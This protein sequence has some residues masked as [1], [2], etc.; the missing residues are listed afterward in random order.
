WEGKTDEVLI[1]L[2][3][4]IDIEVTLTE[5]KAPEVNYRACAFVLM[6]DKQAAKEEIDP[7]ATILSHAEVAVEAKDVPQTPGIVI[8]KL[9]EKAG[10]DIN[11]I[12]LFEI[13]EAFAVVSLVSLEIAKID[14][15]K[16]NVNG[17]AV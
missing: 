12:D 15:E 8:N 16:V 10:K 14:P 2:N 13:N 11:D 17:G 3:P 9:L 4:D 6:S 1:K 5:G 7:L